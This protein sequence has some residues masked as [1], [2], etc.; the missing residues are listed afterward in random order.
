MGD[1][2]SGEDEEREMGKEY[3]DILRKRGV[4]ASLV[5]QWYAR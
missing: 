4:D 1:R 5:G 2:W 3:K